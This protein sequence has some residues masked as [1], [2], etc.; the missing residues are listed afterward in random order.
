MRDVFVTSPGWVGVSWVQVLIKLF[1]GS[2]Q[3]QHDSAPDLLEL[4]RGISLR[5]ATHLQLTL[6]NI[7]RLFRAAHIAVY[8]VWAPCC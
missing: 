2:E 7:V 5:I 8:Y 1:I 4:H 6:E 3:L